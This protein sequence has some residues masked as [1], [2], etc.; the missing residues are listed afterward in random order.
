MKYPLMTL[1]L[2]TTALTISTRLKAQEL[3]VYTEP[4]S[5][6]PAHSMGLR[7]NNWLMKETDGGLINYHFI[8]EVMWGINKNLMIHAEGFLSNRNRSFGA[9]GASVYGKYRFYSHDAVYRHFRMAAF[10]RISYNNAPVHQ[11]EI[12]TNGH[13]SGYELGWVGTQLLHKQA[14]SASLSYER[15]FLPD[16]QAAEQEP[17]GSPHALNYVLS[18]GRLILPKSYSSYGQTNFNVMVELLGQYLPESGRSYLDAAPSVQ[19]IF[20]SQ[21]RFDIGYRHQLYSNMSRTAPSGFL[22]RLEHVIFNAFN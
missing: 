6:M 2:V 4:A 8:P 7:L 17:Q 5:N 10:G 16:Q 20:N 12:E 19:F 22:I 13:N 1:V 11:D 15:A 14:L 18:T 3:F 21:T 9:E